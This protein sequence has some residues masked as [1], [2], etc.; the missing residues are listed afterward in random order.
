M[1]KIMIL[2][3]G[4]CQLSAAIRCRELGISTVLIDY[5]AQPPAAAYADC[6]EQ[7]S[8]FDATACIA[9]AR[10]HRIDG[11]LTLGTDQPVYTAALVAD[12]LGLPAPLPPQTAYAVTNKQQMKA[13]FDTAG[14]PSAP[15]RFLQ[16]GATAAELAGLRP[17]FVIKPVDSQG[18][19]GIALLPTAAD[20]LAHIDTTL[21][22]SRSDSVLVEEYY[23]NAELTISGWVQNG[24]LHLLSVTDRLSHH[25]PPSIGVCYGHRCPSRHIAHYMEIEALSRHIT[26][27]FEIQEGPV[28]YQLLLGSEG[29][30]VNE[31]AARIGGAFEDIFIPAVSGFAILDALIWQSLGTAPD[32]QGLVGYSPQQP[33]GAAGVLLLFCRSG[34]IR[35][36]TPL[37]ELLA[38]PG[39]VAAGYQ[40]QAGDLVPEIRDATARIGHCVILAADGAELDARVAAFWQHFSIRNPAGEE[41]ALPCS[42]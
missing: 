12:A 21:S 37:A 29:L 35:S 27:A 28:Y 6:H 16:R 10:R 1:P 19:R 40:Y 3:G 18:Q 34:R 9:A 2:G 20:V 26:T 24:Q 22:F 7:I 42:L 38:L 30:I 13:I 25:L 14:I 5:T 31:V 39:V 32:L 23:P 8:T 41:L 36:I 15:H 11:V 17:P 33:H 4:N